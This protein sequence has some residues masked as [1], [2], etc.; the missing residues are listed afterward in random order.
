[1][2]NLSRILLRPILL[3]SLCVACN[4]DNPSAPDPAPQEPHPSPRTANV[5]NAVEL[6]DAAARANQGGERTIVLADGI[7][8]LNDMLWLEAE[9]VTVTSASGNRSRVVLEGVGMDGEVIACV[10]STGA[11]PRRGTVGHCPLF[12]P[13]G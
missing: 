9:G 5:A 3:A 1:M 13:L 10:R 7:Y 4:G 12:Y 6:V 11:H 2:K 8:R